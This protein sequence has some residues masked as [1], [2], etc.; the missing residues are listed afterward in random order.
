MD[1][2]THFL[3]GV[4]IGATVTN[5]PSQLVICGL[6]AV[7]PDLINGIPSHAYLLWKKRKEIARFGFNKALKVGTLERWK[8]V[9][10]FF[11][12][13]YE[14]LHSV[15]LTAALVWLLWIWLGPIFGLAWASHILIDLWS[16]KEKTDFKYISS[17]MP[18]FPFSKWSWPWAI[19]WPDYLWLS[20]ILMLVL[21]LYIIWQL[22]IGH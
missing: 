2:G 15:W 7:A 10:Q 14:L 8:E 1:I 5:E 16:H 21:V 9:P 22:F 11:G 3:T 18:F 20:P 12:W 13:L 4:A 6:L 19:S 17:I